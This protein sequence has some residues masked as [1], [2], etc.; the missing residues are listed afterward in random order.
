M[1]KPEL[2]K[3]STIFKSMRLRR[4]ELNPTVQVFGVA[5]PSYHGVMAP[6]LQMPP[7]KQDPLDS[8]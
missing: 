5:L 6:P 7:L 3:V 8:L 1:R 2:S 4:G